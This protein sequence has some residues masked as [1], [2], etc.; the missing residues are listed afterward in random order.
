[1]RLK[2]TRNRSSHE[3]LFQSLLTANTELSVLASISMTAS[4]ILMRRGSGNNMTILYHIFVSLPIY[5]F[6]SPSIIPLFLFNFLVLDELTHFN[7]S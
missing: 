3:S 4:Y 5:L 2:K 6:I 7:L 1:M